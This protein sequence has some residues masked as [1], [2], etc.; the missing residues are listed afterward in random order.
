MHKINL[1]E[2]SQLLKSQP[3]ATVTIND[4]HNT[5]TAHHATCECNNK[6][7]RINNK[8]LSFEYKIDENIIDM[9]VETVFGIVLYGLTYRNT[10]GDIPTWNSDEYSYMEIKV[11]SPA[12]R[13][14]YFEEKQKKEKEEKEKIWRKLG[15]C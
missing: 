7:I 6:C 4:G 9:D 2:F 1:K 10:H 5:L 13:Q 8:H 12:Y 11:D 14:K 15:V 3:D